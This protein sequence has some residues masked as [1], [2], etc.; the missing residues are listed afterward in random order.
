MQISSITG[1]CTPLSELR[2]TVANILN[3]FF[4]YQLQKSYLFDVHE[5]L[6]VDSPGL[7][8]LLSVGRLNGQAQGS[9]CSL[10]FK[11]GFLAGSY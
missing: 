10:G 7:W 3:K 2:N 5:I 4:S 1:A 9:I 6:Y 8:V 11:I